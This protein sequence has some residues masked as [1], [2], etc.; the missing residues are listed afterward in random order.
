MLGL[1]SDGYEPKDSS[2]PFHLWKWCSALFQ[3][4]MLWEL[5]IFTIYWTL[6]YKDDKASGRLD[7]PWRMFSDC[8]DHLF[9]LTCLI[10][11]W[12]LNRIYFDTQY[13]ISLFVASFLS[14]HC[15]RSDT[16]SF[17]NLVLSSFGQTQ[18]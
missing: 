6:L 5:V 7:T 14:I 18:R 1:R 16:I 4:A 2:S 10:F 8:M 12:C 11:E 17:S 3:T 13:A 15:S 9:P